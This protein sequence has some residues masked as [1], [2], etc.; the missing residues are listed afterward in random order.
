MRQKCIDCGKRVPWVSFFGNSFLAVFTVL[1]GVFA[2]SKGLIADGIHSM[3]DVIGTVTVIVTLFIANKKDD[4]KHPWGRGK[5]E[6][7]GA[8]V[9]YTILFLLSCVLLVDAIKMM[10]EGVTE[11]PMMMA[12]FA[13]VISIVLNYT[14]S[15]Y[16]FCAGTRL[17]SPALVA[18]AEENRADMNSSIAVMIGIIGANLGFYWMDPAAAVF[19]A[20]YIMK[21]AIFLIKSSWV[22]L[23][24]KSLPMDKLVLLE[25]AIK[26]YRGVKKIN[27]IKARRIGQSVWLDIEIAMDLKMSV[28]EAS[29]VIREIRLALMRRFD[30]IKDVS[31]AFTCTETIAIKK[32]RRLFAKK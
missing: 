7:T 9:V 3:T 18:N 22:Q 20:F 26:P 2:G 8:L 17:N 4:D 27:F 10:K 23:I 28:R 16:A 5:V 30:Q 24:D 6:F 31:I 14:M 12:F 1:M 11:P 25:N 21:T 15:G 29:A 32:Q 13:T 19:V